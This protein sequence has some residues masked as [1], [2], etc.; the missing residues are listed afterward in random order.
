MRFLDTFHTT[1]VDVVKL[2][3][4]GHA[5]IFCEEAKSFCEESAFYTSIRTMWSSYQPL[6]KQRIHYCSVSPTEHQMKANVTL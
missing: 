6:A 4:I 5:V 1:S 2:L 3:L